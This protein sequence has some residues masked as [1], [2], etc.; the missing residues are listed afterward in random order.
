MEIKQE[1]EGFRK[2]FEIFCA[3]FHEN[4][5]KCGKVAT[6]MTL[7]QEEELTKYLL[8]PQDETGSSS[9]EIASWLENNVFCLVSNEDE[10]HYELHIW[11]DTQ[12]KVVSIENYFTV[13]NSMFAETGNISH[14]KFLKKVNEKYALIPEEVVKYFINNVTKKPKFKVTVQNKENKVYGCKVISYEYLKK[15]VVKKRILTEIFDKSNGKVL[16]SRCHEED[17]LEED[18]FY[19]EKTEKLSDITNT[20]FTEVSSTTYSSNQ[21][22]EIKYLGKTSVAYLPPGEINNQDHLVALSNVIYSVNDFPE[23]TG[24]IQLEFVIPQKQP[25][26]VFS[27]IE[28]L[29]S[30]IEK[31]DSGSKPTEPKTLVK[32]P[33]KNTDTKTRP[34]MVITPPGKLAIVA[35]PKTRGATLKH[36]FNEPLISESKI[37]S[38]SELNA[39]AA[40]DIVETA[41]EEDDDN[42]DDDDD[43]DN[44][45]D[46]LE[47]VDDL[48]EDSAAPEVPAQVGGKDD[49]EV[50]GMSANI[51]RISEDI[52]TNFGQM[53][54]EPTIIK[55]STQ[56]TIE[57]QIE[58]K[59]II[60]EE[61][62]NGDGGSTHKESTNLIGNPFKDL[63]IFGS[64]SAQK[65]QIKSVRME[66]INA[67]GNPFEDSNIICGESTQ[68]EQIKSIKMGPISVIGNPFGESISEGDI[69]SIYGESTL[70]EEIKSTTEQ[71]NVI[72]N[73]FEESMAEADLNRICDESTQNDEMSS[74]KTEPISV[75]KNRFAGLI[76]EAVLNRICRTPAQKKA[77]KLY[78]MSG[79]VKIRIPHAKSKYDLPE[80]DELLSTVVEN[81]S[82]DN[83]DHISC[84]LCGD[85]FKNEDIMEGH[86]CRRKKKIIEYKC[87]KC[88]K[89]YT[90]LKSFHKHFKLEFHFFRFKCDICDVICKELKEVTEHVKVHREGPP[91]TCNQ[92][93][94][95]FRVKNALQ[96]HQYLHT[97][98]KP[99]YG[100]DQCDKA[101]HNKESLK[102]HVQV[103]HSGIT[104]FKCSECEESFASKRVRSIHY[105]KEHE[106]KEPRFSCD[107]CNKKFMSGLLR[108]NHKCE[109]HK[110]DCKICG[111]IF[112]SFR[113]LGSHQQKHSGRPRK[114]PKNK[115]DYGVGTLICPICGVLY[116]TEKT[117]ATHIKR[118]EELPDGYKCDQCEKKF[119]IR[120]K[121]QEHLNVHNGV[122]PFKCDQCDACF[123]SVGKR[124]RHILTYH[125]PP[126]F[127]CD[128]CGKSYKTNR[129]LT[130]H[131]RSH[132]GERP[133]VC[134]VCSK[135][136]SSK[137][138]LR[139][140]DK[141]HKGIR[142]FVC[143][144]CNKAFVQ[145]TNMKSHHRLHWRPKIK[146]T[147][148][149]K[150]KVEPVNQT[151]VEPINQVKVQLIDKDKFMNEGKVEFIK[152]R[153][154]EIIKERKD[155][156]IND[157]KVDLTP[158]GV[159][160]EFINQ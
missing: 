53:S 28:S 81:K 156:I 160:V 10:S 102:E 105:S 62:L 150:V 18:V 95:T 46:F 96:R 110:Y 55:N 1:V 83:P 144:V 140:H 16:Q 122:N 50:R 77:I 153:K 123:P 118:H 157:G 130:I 85:S 134:E 64:D 149:R 73:P 63:N 39:A 44:G 57:N 7:K 60:S 70:K 133:F 84:P 111:E 115:K 158:H 32:T 59:P 120:S 21:A 87:D 112:Q 25:T 13:L 152:E 8:T 128:V 90:D 61:C 125:V 145:L 52:R 117:L 88:E 43:D 121:L 80:M 155:E 98:V 20:K 26:K 17:P 131:Y 86:R 29:L 82:T 15:R 19:V 11:N 36:L 107:H 56:Q 138:L 124:C 103:A 41:M 79:C 71:I 159:K 5:I 127:T 129:K 42:D 154:D 126:R 4:L 24:D 68:K 142:D 27:E 135:A 136:F 151:K 139:I 106:Q 78:K 33:K 146:W 67:I 75:S 30:L 101:Y 89:I 108:L 92:C 113:G 6:V 114:D 54:V 72:G 48:F 37:P 58:E 9:T 69:N 143:P 76:S 100:C 49:V 14:D 74:T 38:Y 97:G 109:N 23:N 31:T 35:N 66:P 3:Q 104:P 116:K 2:E 51:Q 22:L 91:Y 47:N 40:T 137:E 148:K 119:P 147:R 94:K 65:E 99:P 132:T 12:R 45:H 141:S 34:N 93:D